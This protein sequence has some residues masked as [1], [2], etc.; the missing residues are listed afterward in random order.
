MRAF[1]ESLST[2]GAHTIVGNRRKATLNLPLAIW[3]RGWVLGGWQDSTDRIMNLG[4]SL[5]ITF[6]MQLAIASELS[7]R[8]SKLRARLYTAVR[9]TD[10]YARAAQLLAERRG[11][12][13]LSRCRCVAFVDTRRPHATPEA[14]PE[15]FTRSADGRENAAE[16][17]PAAYEGGRR[18]PH[19]FHHPHRTAP[20]TLHPDFQIARRNRR[21]AQRSLSASDARLWFDETPAVPLWARHWRRASEAAR[22]LLPHARAADQRGKLRDLFDVCVRCGAIG[23]TAARQDAVNV[24]NGSNPA[25]YGGFEVTKKLRRAPRQ[26]KGPRNVSAAGPIGRNVLS[27]DSRG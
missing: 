15:E 11:T 14:H 4:S 26:R 9:Q 23:Q 24:G 21:E 27:L 6:R 10:A 18:Q 5:L 8:L 17:P 25:G 2:S 3:L 16:G 12:Q 19:P 22:N 13:R 20:P 7:I 1:P